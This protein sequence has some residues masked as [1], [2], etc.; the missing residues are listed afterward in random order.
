MNRLTDAQRDAVATHLG[1]AGAIARGFRGPTLDFVDLVQAG[2][3]G[4]AEA[5]TR[6]EPGRGVQFSTYASHWIKKEMRDALRAAAAI[7]VDP[8]HLRKAAA[9]RRAAAARPGADFA[10]VCDTLGITRRSRPTLAA[11]L[12]I[13]ID[14]E[15]DTDQK[16]DHGDEIEDRAEAITAALA[17]LSDSDAALITRRFGLDGEP[18]E[19]HRKIRDRT[20]ISHNHNR[21]RQV[22]AL[23]HLSG[24]S[25]LEEYRP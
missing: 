9:Y 10:E 4:I 3:L 7:R 16:H 22:V 15:A 17:T 18:T 1:L 20:G 14:D 23:Q 12:R 19:S 2:A 8:R 11:A 21:Y 6:F 13:H 24:C 5:V 25:Q